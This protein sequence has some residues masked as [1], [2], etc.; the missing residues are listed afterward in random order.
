MNANNRIP[1]HQAV[2]ELTVNNHPGVM[3]HVCG[4]F[5]R[6]A[7]NVDGILCMPMTDR[8]HSRIWLRV[9]EN[10]RL[11]QVVSQLQK[12]HDVHQVVRHSPEHEVFSRLALF[13]ENA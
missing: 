5:S 10:E 4:L 12:L 3:S 11:N 13:F 7:F 2:L 8:A 6:R 9:Q 1:D